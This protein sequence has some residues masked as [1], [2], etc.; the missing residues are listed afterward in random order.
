MATPIVSTC[1]VHEGIPDKV[2]CNKVKYHW[3]VSI[4]SFMR[5]R[6]KKEEI[7]YTIESK[8]KV[9][10]YYSIINHVYSNFDFRS[11]EKLKADFCLR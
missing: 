4:F 10:F 1:P 3:K 8:V 6:N 11:D 2:D 7:K 9:T 5:R